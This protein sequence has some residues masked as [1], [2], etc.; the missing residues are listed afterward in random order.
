L[1]VE[2]LGFTRVHPVDVE[3]RG[4][5]HEPPAPHSLSHTHTHTVSLSHTHSLFLSHTHPQ[6]LSVFRVEGVGFTRVHPVDV[7]RRRPRHEPPAPQV[8]VPRVAPVLPPQGYEDL[9]SNVIPRRARPGLAGLGPHKG[10]R[11]PRLR[12]HI[13]LRREFV[14]DPTVEYPNNVDTA[15]LPAALDTKA[16]S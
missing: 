9:G 5:R 7:E 1:R 16:G 15:S 6:F 8:V 14:E 12:H 2:G 11:S 10:P 3:R 13:A 4:A